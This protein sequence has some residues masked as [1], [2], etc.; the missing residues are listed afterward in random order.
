MELH[1]ADGHKEGLGDFGIGHAAGGHASHATLPRRQRPCPVHEGTPR[2]GARGAQAVGRSQL[3]RR[4]AAGM[5][6]IESDSECRARF[7]ILT[8]CLQPR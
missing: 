1:R 2:T 8:R 6:E 5:S 4:G 3:Q 7:F